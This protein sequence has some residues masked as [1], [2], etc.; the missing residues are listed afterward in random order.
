MCSRP[1]PLCLTATCLHT[2]SDGLLD[3]QASSTSSDRLGVWDGFKQHIS[4]HLM[5]SSVYVHLLLASGELN[6]TLKSFDP[7]ISQITF[8]QL[9]SSRCQYHVCIFMM[10]CHS[11]EYLACQT[12]NQ[13]PDK[14]FQ[15][16]YISNAIADCK[17]VAVWGFV[18]FAEDIQSS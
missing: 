3:Y 8:D 15:S 1:P 7:K 16:Q 18:V 13:L 4:L 11:L 14:T 10:V 6:C 12:V 5:I 9:R 17:Q 2:G